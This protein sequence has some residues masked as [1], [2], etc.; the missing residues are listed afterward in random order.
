MQERNRTV[1]YLPREKVEREVLSFWW[2]STSKTPAR[3]AR[4]RLRTRALG[5]ELEANSGARNGALGCA[6][7]AAHVAWPRLVGPATA[8]DISHPWRFEFFDPGRIVAFSIANAEIS[9]QSIFA[10][11]PSRTF[12]ALLPLYTSMESPCPTPS[13]SKN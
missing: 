10:T 1:V 9:C 12:H 6:S 8:A 11:F 13:A 4:A 7:T 5:D 2:S 3:R